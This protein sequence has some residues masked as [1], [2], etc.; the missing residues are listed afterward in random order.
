MGGASQDWSPEQIAG[1]M[2]LERHPIRVSHETIYRYAYS[3]DSRSEE[4]Y[5]HLP[6]HRR[7]RRPRGMWRPH[8]LRFAPGNSIALR[9]VEVAGRQ[10]FGHWE[11]DLT[12]FRKEFGSANG[13]ALI[14]RVSRITLQ[15]RPVMEAVIDGL[16]ALPRAGA[17]LN[18]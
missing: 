13:T 3:P 8:G 16:S 15:S 17:P 2:K 10:Q 5:R 7:Q 9:P 4:L 1:R 6:R 14:E 18:F 11:W 12:L